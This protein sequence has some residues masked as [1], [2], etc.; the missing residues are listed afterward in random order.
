MNTTK[1]LEKKYKPLVIILSI[2]IPVVVAL[3]FGV[4]VDGVDLTF[5]PAIYASINGLTA[6]LL[7]AAVIMIKKGNRTVHQK[8]M[9]SAVVCSL[10]FLVMYVAYHMTSDST[11]YGDINGDGMQDPIEEAK[12]GSSKYIYYF[13]LISHILLSVIVIP[14]VMLTYLKGWSG[15]IDQHKKWAKFTFPIWLYV[16]V[17]G[18]VVYFMIS[19]YY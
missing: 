14:L 12:I 18:V 10:L 13:I 1:D 19:P 3:L 11:L 4:K 16:A 7:I 8:L 5:F 6:L 2:V 15:K 9:T 17:T